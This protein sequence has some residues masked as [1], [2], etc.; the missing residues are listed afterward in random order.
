LFFVVVGYLNRAVCRRNFDDE[1]DLVWDDEEEEEPEEEEEE[2]DEKDMTEEEVREIVAFIQWNST[3]G[4][5]DSCRSMPHRKRR[6]CARMRTR[7]SWRT[8]KRRQR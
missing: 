5:P 1:E 3:R 6:R 2:K 7:R 4:S 8:Q